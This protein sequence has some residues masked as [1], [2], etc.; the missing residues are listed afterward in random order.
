MADYDAIISAIT[1]TIGAVSPAIGAGV[2]VVKAA[3]AIYDAVGRDEDDITDEDLDQMA[4]DSDAIHND[5]QKPLD[6][7]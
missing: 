3:K 4:A 5:V 7:E 1:K 6:D 2:E